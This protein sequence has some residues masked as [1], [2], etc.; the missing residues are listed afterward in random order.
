MTK[1]ILFEVL[2]LFLEALIIWL[3][4]KITVKNSINQQMDLNFA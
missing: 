3:Y 1:A 2:V 4:K